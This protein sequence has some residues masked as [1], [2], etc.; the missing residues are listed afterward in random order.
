LAE[1][2]GLISANTGGVLRPALLWK[3]KPMDDQFRDLYNLPD[4]N[5]LDQ[6]GL[7]KQINISSRIADQSHPRL[8][9]KHPDHN[10]WMEYE[11]SLYDRR[12]PKKTEAQVLKE[13]EGLKLFAEERL[14][15]AEEK[16]VEI[17][18]RFV[19]DELKSRWGRE[20]DRNIQIA[21]AA[22]SGFPDDFKAFLENSEI[23]GKPPLGSDPEFIQ[24]VHRAA[25]RFYSRMEEIEN[26][27][28]RLKRRQG[29]NL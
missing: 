11:S 5:A 20:Y 9:K 16:Q 7:D 21:Q 24:D 12:Y 6:P 17:E 29:G 23:D 1:D 4:P 27:K 26:R 25:K 3:G 8:N 22:I 2:S 10:S 14:A 15:S 28:A 18:K 19:L 13:Q